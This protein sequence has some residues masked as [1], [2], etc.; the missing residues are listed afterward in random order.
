MDK[1]LHKTHRFATRPLRFV[2][3]QITNRNFFHRCRCID[4][5]NKKRK[6][7]FFIDAIYGIL[8]LRICL[9]IWAY[10]ITCAPCLRVIRIKQKLVK[11]VISR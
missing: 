6:L 1:V 8:L 10:G 9:S 5:A 4:V 11:K 2:F 7:I 3:G